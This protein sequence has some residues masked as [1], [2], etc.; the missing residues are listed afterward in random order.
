MESMLQINQNTV[1]MFK[2]SK[3]N[4]NS[5]NKANILLNSRMNY[6]SDKENLIKLNQSNIIYRT[7]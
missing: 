1:E 2:L 7:N 6:A 3:K 4:N 5:A